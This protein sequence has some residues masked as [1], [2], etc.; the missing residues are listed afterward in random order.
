MNEQDTEEEAEKIEAEYFV[1]YVTISGSAIQAD[2]ST[3]KSPK[4]R[5]FVSLEGVAAEGF[6]GYTDTLEDAEKMGEA[7]IA[8]YLITE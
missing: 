3:S 5:Y 2:I 4:G 6:N 7:L 1:T 8:E